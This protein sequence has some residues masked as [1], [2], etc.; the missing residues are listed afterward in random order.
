MLRSL[1]SILLLTSLT[2]WSD[3]APLSAAPK[4]VLIVVNDDQ[5]QQAGCYGDRQAKTP[6]LDALA[7]DGTRFD[8]AF[9]TS[10]SCSPSR[11]VIL[12]G[13]Y[14]HA[15]GQYGLA[16]ADH[17]FHTRPFVVGLPNLLQAAGYRTL[18]AGKHHVIPESQF[19]FEKSANAKLNLRSTVELAE[20]V[21]AFLKEPD[22]RPFFIYY[23]PIDPHRAAQGY[24]NDKRYPGVTEVEY[25]PAQIAI[26]AWLPDL[27]ETRADLAGFYQ[28]IARAD[29]G[30]GRV[31]QA[32]KATGHY[33]DTLIL[34]LADNGPPFPG[35]KTTL[36][37]PGVRLPLVV[38]SPEQ[39]T[40]GVISQ[41]LVSWVDLTPTVLAWTGAKS[42]KYP[43]SGRSILPLL[44]GQAVAGWDHVFFSHNFHEVTMYYPMR[45]IR[46]R[47]YK[48][49]RNLAHPLSFPFAS[50]LWESPTW[51]ATLQ[52]S[53][54][55]YG[56]RE[57]AAYLHRP[58]VELYD[59]ETD[60]GETRNLAGQVE[61][62]E[63]E[64]ELLG[65]IEQWQRT[66]GDPWVVKYSHE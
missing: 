22:D 25:D 31:I 5:G 60:P 45:G 15:S 56:Q 43:L 38:R 52:K 62:S 1:V 46:T 54:T 26:P 16:H 37:E 4:N 39:Q 40:R 13:L 58:A 7:A 6:H 64:A 48:C 14:G 11:S 42:P 49:L 28:A 53:L 34:C 32:L 50:D 3:G 9:C 59:L 61:Y 19:A 36:Y 51:Q 24:G 63:V 55:K 29:Q 20:R 47:K 12:S 57:V 18:L 17:N 30:L 66:T 10:A 35:A 33:E 23:C 2:L 27:P 65:R 21:E 8:L 41:S 44:E